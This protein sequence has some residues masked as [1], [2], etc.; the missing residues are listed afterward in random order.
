ML[1]HECYIFFRFN[2]KEQKRLHPIFFPPLF[3]T[4][5]YNIGI[6]YSLKISKRNFARDST[7][8][9]S[10]SWRII[11]WISFSFWL[12]LWNVDVPRPEMEL[13]PQQWPKLLRWRCWILNSLCYKRTPENFISRG[14]RL[15][16]EVFYFFRVR[17]FLSFFFFLRKSSNFMRIY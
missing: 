7:G 14:K 1:E 11:L 4:N 12:H 8:P 15:V 6:M 3:W 17:V 10:F 16:L 5:L 2:N 9:R 13:A